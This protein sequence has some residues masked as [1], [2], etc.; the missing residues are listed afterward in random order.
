MECAMKHRMLH[1]RTVSTHSLLLSESMMKAAPWIAMRCKARVG[2]GGRLRACH[3][4]KARVGAGG[5]LR[6]CHRST[7]S[8]DR[9]QHSGSPQLQRV[10]SKDE[11]K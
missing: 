1:T 10:A 2:V 9:R 5:R 6:A 4:C 8:W 3:N 7:A 11:L